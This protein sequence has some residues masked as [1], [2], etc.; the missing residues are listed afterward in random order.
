MV[1]EVRDLIPGMTEQSVQSVYWQGVTFVQEWMM[2]NVKPTKVFGSLASEKE[3]RAQD[4]EQVSHIYSSLLL[5]IAVLLRQMIHRPEK[6]E[7]H[8]LLRKRGNV[9]QPQPLSFR[10]IFAPTLNASA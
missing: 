10:R 3:V 2:H 6:S 4:E 8:K 5:D 9:R 7:K 1:F